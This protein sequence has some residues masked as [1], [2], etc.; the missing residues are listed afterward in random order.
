MRL[1]PNYSP[2]FYF[3]AAGTINL[4][5]SPGRFGTRCGNGTLPIDETSDGPFE[6]L[7]GR[8]PYFTGS[9]AVQAA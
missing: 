9:L 2:R 4:I 5:D 6:L 7:L 3:N 8:G 1:T